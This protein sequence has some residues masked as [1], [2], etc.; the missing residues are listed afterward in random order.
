[1]SNYR[2]DDLDRRILTELAKNARLSNMELAELVPLSHSAI[3]RRVSRLESEGA[4]LGYG[5]HIDPA[6]LGITIRAFVGVRRD[7]AASPEELSRGLRA[8]PQ[9]AGC[10]IV[11]GEH[12]FFLEVRAQDMEHFSD[13]IL[14]RVQKVPGV[15]A[16]VST[17]VLADLQTEQALARA[18]ATGKLDK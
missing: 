16:T 10:W 4:I 7:P 17:F 12:D 18:L 5:A 15:L 14:K 3:S 11:S 6:A 8:I 2:L 13:V 9:V 1:M